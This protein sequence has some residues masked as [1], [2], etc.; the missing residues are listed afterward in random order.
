M[1]IH[2]DFD[3]QLGQFSLMTYEKVYLQSNK[4]NL[5]I[6]YIIY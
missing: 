3:P 1:S 2:W 5:E 4:V 6:K